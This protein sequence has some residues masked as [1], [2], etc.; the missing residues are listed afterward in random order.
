MLAQCALP[1]RRPHALG[2]G[3]IGCDRSEDD[4][5]GMRVENEVSARFLAISG[6][7][8]TREVP[9]VVGDGLCAECQPAVCLGR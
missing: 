7:R 5:L 2:G 4:D 3:R 9:C 6:H 8:G 1:R